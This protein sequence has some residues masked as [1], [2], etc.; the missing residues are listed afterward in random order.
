MS[1]CANAPLNASDYIRIIKNT[2]TIHF[3]IT[4]FLRAQRTRIFW[5]VILLIAVLFGLNA[6]YKSFYSEPRAVFN[7]MIE[8][9]LRTGSVT[10]QIVQED[11]SQSLDQ[12][13]RLQAGETHRAQSVTM[14]SQT[15]LAS[16]E[17]VTESIGTATGDF[18][19]YRSINTD[20]KGAN[21]N[22]LDFSRVLGIWGKT[23]G[24]EST[25][26]EL[27]NEMALSVIPLG[28][29]PQ[30]SRRKLMQIVSD[31]DVYKVEYANVKRGTVNGRPSYEYT[32]KVNPEDY[33]TFL[34][35]YAEAVGLT[36][37]KNINPANYASAD[38]IE[39]KVTVDVRTRRLSSVTYANGRQERYLSYG[40]HADVELPKDAV[41]VEELQSRLQEVQ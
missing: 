18:V 28:N 38:A 15:G 5:L 8:N 20:Q 9:S 1:C 13:V 41:T 14:L 37:L 39:F 24:S 21:G 17:V 19:R 2:D 16:A 29:V 25:S 33:V 6:W 30:S 22:D 3:M 32:V 35:A 7:A 4:T 12:T 31:L 10:K 40:T 27:Y 11:Q 26:G 34:K 36:H 23:E